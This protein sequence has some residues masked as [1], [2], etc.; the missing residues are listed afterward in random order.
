MTWHWTGTTPWLDNTT[1]WRHMV[2]LDH[3]KLHSCLLAPVDLCKH[4]IKR[5]IISNRKNTSR[6]SWLNPFQW[7]HNERDGVSDNQR[8]ECLFDRLFRRISK[9]T[10]KLCCTGLCEGNS[11]VIGEFLSQ[12]ASNA[13]N[14][15]ILWRHH[16]IRLWCMISRS[17]DSVTAVIW[18]TNDW[19]VKMNN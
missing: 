1:P 7:R 10:S 6:C 16:S 13:E 11:P 3:R 12:R 15:S 9:K 8:L 5:K 14:V 2:S 19:M 17:V 4:S 18:L